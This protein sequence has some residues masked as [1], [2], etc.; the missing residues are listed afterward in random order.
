MEHPKGSV[1]RY[2]VEKASG[3]RCVEF[4]KYYRKM[5]HLPENSRFLRKLS[6]RFQFA[7][8]DDT[9]CLLFNRKYSKKD[10][11]V[12]RVFKFNGVWSFKIT[13]EFLD[14]LALDSVLDPVYI[15][16]TDD[17]KILVSKDKDKVPGGVYE[18]MFGAKDNCIV[19]LSRVNSIDGNIAEYLTKYEDGVCVMVPAL[20]PD[21]VQLI[22]NG[23]GVYVSVEPFYD[24][25]KK[26]VDGEKVYVSVIFNDNEQRVEFMK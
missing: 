11:D 4:V 2:P 6:V 16:V 9:V 22:V 25:I 19:P 18:H 20:Y 5:Y 10:Y 15:A 24:K 23:S 1:F 3:C 21:E 26:E 17:L 8:T 12:T 14:G 13:N 7:E